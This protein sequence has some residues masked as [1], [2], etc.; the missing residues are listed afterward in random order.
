[1]TSVRALLGTALSLGLLLWLG[2]A[3]AGAA[4]AKTSPP[5]AGI[6]L[7]PFLQQLSIAPD[8]QSQS[9]N[10][11]VTNHTVTVQELKLTARDFGSLDETGGVLLEGSKSY[12]QKYGLVSWLDL[13]T[14][15]L[16]LQP[17]ETRG[18]LITIN[19]KT[20]LRPG[21]HYGAI[22][23]SVAN[24]AKPY[25]NQVGINQQLLSLILL[26]KVGGER[27][28]LR[29]DSIK[30]NGNWFKLPDEVHLRFKN[31][32]NVH[33]VPRG[34]VKLKSPGAQP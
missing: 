11:N 5:I 16:V 23:A 33:V 9:F 13:E 27:Y 12:N 3:W 25:G 6:T 18:V 8:D 19:N 20:S 22:V 21:G 14:D 29:L 15:S 24:A 10:L 32:G 7:S 26:N 30:Q 4:P 2:P 31:P 34:L 1:M 17:K 28:D